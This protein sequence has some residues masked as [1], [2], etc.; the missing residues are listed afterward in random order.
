MWYD[1]RRVAKEKDLI[2]GIPRIW[3][4][5]NLLKYVFYEW[6]FSVGISTYKPRAI[7]EW[8]SGKRYLIILDPY[9]T[10]M[11]T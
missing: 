11:Y 1:M 5:N 3:K 6:N 7:Y 8:E 10:P 9:C 2:D 4:I